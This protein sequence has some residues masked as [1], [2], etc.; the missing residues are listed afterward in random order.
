MPLKTKRIDL[1]PMRN[2][3]HYQF[4]AEVKALI[5]AAGPQK[6]NIADDFT[7]YSQLCND[8]LDALQLIRKSA[9]SDQLEDADTKRDAVFR[10]LVDAV[11][12]AK[13]H[14]VEAK[15]EAAARLSI[16]LDQYGNV[17]RKP[18][19][20][21][22]AAITKLLKEL[23]EKHAPDAEL[24]GLNDWVAELAARNNAF[25]TLM[26]SRFTE[27]AERTTLRMRQVRSTIDLQF[28]AILTRI[29][30][31]VI[32]NGPAE[33]TAFVREL[34]ARIDKYDNLVAVRQ[35]KAAAVK[36]KTTN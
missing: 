3:E 18:Y 22:S 11:K 17:A 25:D 5:V 12:S 33:Y 8:E 9:L 21:E 27:D 26:K 29:D 28:R 32:V 20:E 19:N 35:G 4:H 23:A 1:I 2:E 13:N 14:F 10:G 30:A 36:D 15:K 7:D 24:L 31:L 34:N 6:L 16:V